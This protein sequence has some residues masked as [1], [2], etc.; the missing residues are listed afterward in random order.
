MQKYERI[1]TEWTPQEKQLFLPSQGSRALP[2][3]RKKWGAHI[4][5]S[6]P[7]LALCYNP[8]ARAAAPQ[9]FRS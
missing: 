2:G 6:A 8:V 7:W 9:L 1:F 5:V 4:A 3:A